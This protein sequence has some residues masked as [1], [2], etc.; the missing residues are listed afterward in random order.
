MTIQTD[1]TLHPRTVT[2]VSEGE[3]RRTRRYQGRTARVKDAYESTAHPLLMAAA[4][5]ALRPG[6]RLVVVSATEVHIVN[7]KG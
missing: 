1:A 4:K 2:E 7:R 6:E 5:A 3:H